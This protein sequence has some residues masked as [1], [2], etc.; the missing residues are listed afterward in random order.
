MSTIDRINQRFPKSIT[1]SA[2]GINTGWQ[3]PVEHLSQH[4]TTN[5]NEL[6]VV[7]CN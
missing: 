1:F 4:Y 7:N 3:V 6:A 2:T 5:W